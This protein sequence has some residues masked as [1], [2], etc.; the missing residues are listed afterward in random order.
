MVLD[1]D[2]SVETR[3]KAKVGKSPVTFRGPPY[4]F[5]S[6]EGWCSEGGQNRSISQ[7]STILQNINTLNSVSCKS[8]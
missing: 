1:R 3:M 7:T 6:G 2:G 8:R 4:G 5:L